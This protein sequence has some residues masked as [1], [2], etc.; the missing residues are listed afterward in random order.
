MCRNFVRVLRGTWLNNVIA[1][2]EAIFFHK[3]AAFSM[4]FYTLLHANAHY[5]NFF[6][7]QMIFKIAPTHFIHYVHPGGVTGHVMVMVMFWMYTS[8]H[9]SIRRQSFELFWYVHHLFTV[10]YL[11]LL[12]HAVGCF[13]RSKEGKC[14]PYGSWPWTLAACCLY[15]IERMI[16]LYRAYQT[17][18]INQIVLHPNKTLEVRFEKSMSYK[19]GQYI[20]VNVPAVSQFQWHP[21]TLTS[22]PED[23]YISVHMRLVGDWT[24]DVARA[25]GAF[26]SLSTLNS[27]SLPRLCIDGPF[28]APAQDLFKKEVAVLIGAGIGVTPFA[29]LLKSIWYKFDKKT[30]MRLKKVLFVWT[31]R[32]MEAFE[33]FHELLQ[34]IEH[35]ITPEQLEI[36]VYLTGKVAS[37][38]IH[39]LVINTTAEKDALTDLKSLTRFGRPNMNAILGSIK[40]GILANKINVENRNNCEVGVFYCGPDSFANSIHK[41]CVATTSASIQFNLYKEHF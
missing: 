5:I 14:K 25:F 1:F 7:A 18:T 16:R 10:F 32:E 37:D 33:W 26:D 39:N 20:F 8:A 36:Q 15:V 19:P 21:F 38:D 22:V 13:V 12:T 41:S 4:L 6:N 35:S 40:S 30:P 17:T 31:N 3:Q 34:T 9:F 29:S 28:G 23:G 2:D 11:A 24:N 27:Q